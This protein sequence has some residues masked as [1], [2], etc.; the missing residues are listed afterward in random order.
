MNTALILGLGLIGGSAGMALRRRGWRVAYLDPYVSLD[1]AVRAGAADE[2]VEQIVDADVI[3]L[4][5]PVDAAIAF[6]RTLDANTVVTS[7]CSVM[8]ALRDVA[9]GTF[10][11]GHPMAGSHESGLAAARTDLFEGKPWF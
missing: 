10:V 3:V 7:T 1:D 2:R 4:A 9:R 5:T 11:A 8:R 6:L